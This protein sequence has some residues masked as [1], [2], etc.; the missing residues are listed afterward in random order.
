MGFFKNRNKDKGAAY[1]P[2]VAPNS[3]FTRHFVPPFVDPPVTLVAPPPVTLVA[4]P[5]TLV[6]PPVTL[7]APPVTLVE[8]PFA[9]LTVSE[10][11]TAPDPVAIANAAD[12][13]VTL[14]TNNFNKEFSNIQTMNTFYNTELINSKNTSSLYDVYQT[15]NKDLESDIKDFY[16][17][18]L[19]NDRKTYY[20]IG[21]LEVLVNWNHFFL[22]M[23]YALFV[24]FVLG[25][26][27]S[28]NMIPKYQSI[29]LAIILGFY[30]FLISP[31][32]G[33]LG[34]VFTHARAMYPKNVYNNL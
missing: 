23:Y 30:P 3:P 17:D 20:E 1:V 28:E 24:A 25:I 8:P 14:K 16:S 10:P 18:V 6:A 4:P 19:T 32:V 21:A 12:A 13:D 27:F 22:Y 11:L 15:K 9:P 33:K 7:A 5:V 31:I 34:S 29:S 2:F 26:V